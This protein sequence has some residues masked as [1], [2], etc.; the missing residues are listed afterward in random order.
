MYTSI[1]RDSLGHSYTYIDV[2]TNTHTHTHTHTHGAV[3]DIRDVCPRDV[4]AV[5]TRQLE[6]RADPVRLR[7]CAHIQKPACQRATA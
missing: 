4:V 5:M 2:H 1:T 3:P 6:I 7:V